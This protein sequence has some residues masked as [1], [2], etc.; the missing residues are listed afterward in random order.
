M[1]EKKNTDDSL[2][3][4]DRDEGLKEF[5]DQASEAMDDGGDPTDLKAPVGEPQHRRLRV[6]VSEDRM[7]A[8]LEGVF[9]DTKLAEVQEALKRER[10]IWGVQKETLKKAVGQADSSGRHQRDIPAAKGKPAVYL[11]RKQVEYPFLEGL[12]QLG[13]GEP[14]H[15]ASSVLREIDEVMGY[16]NIG[17]IRRYGHPIVAVTARSLLMEVQGEDVIE[18]VEM[19]SESRSEPLWV[20]SRVP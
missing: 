2:E 20:K 4:K 9:P 1:A 17:Q 13:T 15:I 18:P 3:E 16:I 6:I 19:S 14:V 10:V 11:K 5:L 12:R 8:Q 7:E